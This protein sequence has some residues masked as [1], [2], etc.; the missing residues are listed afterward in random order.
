MRDHRI[1]TGGCHSRCASSDV[2]AASSSSARSSP[3][4]GAKLLLKS[5]STTTEVPL[6]LVLLTEHPPKATASTN[7]STTRD[8]DLAR[9]MNRLSKSRCAKHGK[10]LPLAFINGMQRRHIATAQSEC[11]GGEREGHDLQTKD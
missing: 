9:D 7:G 3:T 8:L 4:R 10:R 2:A 6:D 1:S 11:W 5:T